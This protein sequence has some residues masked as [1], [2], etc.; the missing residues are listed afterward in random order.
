MLLEIWFKEGAAAQV[1]LFCSLEKTTMRTTDKNPL[2][3]PWL[4]QSK[5]KLF[6][7]IFFV[8]F[9]ALSKLYLYTSLAGAPCDDGFLCGFWRYIGEV[10]FWRVFVY[11]TLATV[12]ICLVLLSYWGRYKASILYP[13]RW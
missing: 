12:P 6:T 3:W 9:S 13:S 5:A 1:A 11:E 2:F 10:D 4:L 7:I 8:I